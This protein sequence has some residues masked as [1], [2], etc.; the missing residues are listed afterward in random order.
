MPK[1]MIRTPPGTRFG[2]LVVLEDREP[3]RG[4]ITVR[5]RCDCGNDTTVAA[6]ELRRGRIKS[7]GCLR[8]ISPRTA[9]GRLYPRRLTP[10]LPDPDRG[11]GPVTRVWTPYETEEL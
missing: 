11:S 10:N 1:P 4:V 8:R 6:T 3:G 9:P 7:C 5:C 2:R